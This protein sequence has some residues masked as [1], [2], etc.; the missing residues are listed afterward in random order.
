M[1]RKQ[2]TV[3]EDVLALFCGFN[4]KVK[5]GK[6]YGIVCAETGEPLTPVKYD[7]IEGWTQIFGSKDAAPVRLDGKWGCINSRGEEIIAPKF[8]KVEISQQE[9]PYFSAKLNGK[10]GFI[11]D[12]GKE[13][14]KFEYDEVAMFSCARAFVQKDNKFGFID[15]AGNIVVPVK[16]DDCEYFFRNNFNG[17]DLPVWVK[18]NGLYGFVDI[19]GH[20]IVKPQYEYALSFGYGSYAAVVLEG[21]AGFIDPTGKTVIPCMYEP[22]FKNKAACYYRFSGNYASVKQGGKWGV[23]NLDNEVVIPFVYDKFLKNN[24]AGF[25]YAVRNGKKL[26]VDLKGNERELKKNPEARTFKDYLHA[27]EW[28]TVAESF[29]THIRKRY[30]KVEGDMLIWE[31]NFLNFRSKRHKHSNDIIRIHENYYRKDIIEVE[32]FSVRGNCSYTFFDWDKILDMEV[33][34]EDNLE[35]ADADVVAYVIWRAVDCYPK[36][37]ERINSFLGISEKICKSLVS[38]R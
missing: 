20:E 19:S 2:K 3:N 35:L 12:E 5:I 22:Y 26:S 14:T 23:I 13:V 28:A 31:S 25:Q 30:K 21:K 11:D 32:L 38:S 9:Q 8:E 18:S 33:R 15:T 16:Y 37:E 36:T 29:E 24:N 6:K 7:E 10:W 34:I 17:T 27:V 4:R 1:S